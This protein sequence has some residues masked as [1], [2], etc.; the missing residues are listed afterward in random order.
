M[1]L[2]TATDLLED[3]HYPATT[4]EL[5][6]A[7]GNVRIEHPTGEESLDEVLARTGEEEFADATEAVHAVIGAVGQD[8]VGRV[9]YSDRDPTPMGVDG[10]EPVSF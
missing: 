3:A 4:A 9:G 8:A 1:T 5:R 6:E 7:Y 2:R 10:H